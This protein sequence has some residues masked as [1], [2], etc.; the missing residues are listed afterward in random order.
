MSV[1]LLDANALSD[2]VRN[3]TGPVS[4]KVVDKGTTAVC[5]SVVVAAEIF[6]GVERRASAVFAAK[7]R[8]L[9]EKI[10]VLPLEPPADEIYGRVRAALA[11]AGTP[12]GPNDLFIAAHALALD[13]VLVTD[14]VKE[15]SRVPGLKIENW[16]RA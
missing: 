1:F 12:I 9:F 8:R 10:S 4:R 16:L 15:F 14:N 2:I 11:K 13:A 7:A 6:F 5:T 3:P